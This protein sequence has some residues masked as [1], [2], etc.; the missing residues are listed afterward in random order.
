MFNARFQTIVPIVLM[1][2]TLIVGTAGYITAGMPGYDGFLTSLSLLVLNGPLEPSNLAIEVARWVGVIFALD[3]I[4]SIITVSI[5][6]FSEDRVIAAKAKRPGT[7]AVHGDGVFAKKMVDNLGDKAIYSDRDASFTAPCQVV[8]FEHDEDAIAF[9]NKNR[10]KLAAADEAYIGL[11]ELSTSVSETKGDV[12]FFSM[13]DIAA[14]LYWENYPITEPQT[15]IIIGE[16]SYA[17]SL[18]T[19]G[20]LV[21]LFDIEGGVRYL[22]FGNFDRYRRLHT[23]LDDVLA[24]NNDE[25][26]FPEDTW[27]QHVPELK[28]AGRI[29]LCGD[30]NKSLSR[31]T[32]LVK[33][34]IHVPLHIRVDSETSRN[35]FPMDDP[36][37]EIVLFGTSEQ[38][39]RK[40]IVIQQEQHDAGK[41]CDAAYCLGTELCNGC[42]LQPNYPPDVITDETPEDQKGRIRFSRLG[43]IDFSECLACKR[44]DDQW[45]GMDEFTK[46]SNYASA[47]HDSQ[48]I[49]LL[50]RF[51]VMADGSKR[52]DDLTLEERDY[53]QEVEHIRWERFHFMNNWTFA[54]KFKVVE[55]DGTEVWKQKNPAARTHAYLVPYDKLD[56]DIK[57]L[58][59]DSFKTVFERTRRRTNG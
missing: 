12:F 45:H 52:F 25:L 44:H 1:V 37:V 46:T 2:V 26:I 38:L 54:P 29:I 39:C 36:N 47:A 23:Q 35:L 34:G 20:L 22:V 5:A 19:Q 16:G 42:T 50:E 43:A 55:N 32:D 4:L 51:G 41:I 30:N 18:L 15:V 10:D 3:I 28:T 56:R 14:E 49:R 53:L 13:A 8:L 21:N 33:A 24:C 11:N 27:C 48:K 58:D 31:A 7:I 57:D 17:E 59:G 6:A 40:A 9:Y